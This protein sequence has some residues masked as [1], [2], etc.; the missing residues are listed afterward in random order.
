MVVDI[1][2][3]GDGVL[4]GI[5]E[6][7]I[8]LAVAVQHSRRRRDTGMATVSA[9]VAPVDQPLDVETGVSRSPLFSIPDSK[10]ML[11]ETFR[12]ASAMTAVGVSLPPRPGPTATPGKHRSVPPGLSRFVRGG[13]AEPPRAPRSTVVRLC[14]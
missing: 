12:S 3:E 1:G 8:E 10:W 13:V 14:G 9:D 11:R 5:V 6:R 4:T 2:D 7:P